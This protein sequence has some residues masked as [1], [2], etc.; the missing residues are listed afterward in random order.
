MLHEFRM[1]QTIDSAL[2]LATGL[3]ISTTVMRSLSVPSQRFLFL[4][5]VSEWLPRLIQYLTPETY[6]NVV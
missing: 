1:V 2:L 3:A 4:M 6:L 5:M